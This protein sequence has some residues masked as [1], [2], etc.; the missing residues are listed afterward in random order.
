MFTSYVKNKYSHDT[1]IFGD[2][3][4]GKANQG[5]EVYVEQPLASRMTDTLTMCTSSLRRSMDLKSNS[6]IKLWV[7]QVCSRVYIAFL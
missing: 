4:Q 2:E 3:N 1:I 6:T 5:G 7:E